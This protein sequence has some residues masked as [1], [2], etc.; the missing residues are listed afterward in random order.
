VVFRHAEKVLAAAK[1]L[2]DAVRNIQ[3]DIKSVLKTGTTRTYA[4]VMMPYILGSFQTVL[5]L[6]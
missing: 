3:V 4:R 2:Q 1:E 5:A 6:I